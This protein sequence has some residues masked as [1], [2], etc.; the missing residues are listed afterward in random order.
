MKNTTPTPN[1]SLMTLVI[2]AVL[3]ALF[4]AACGPKEAPITVPAD[5]QAG[6][7]IVEPCT[8]KISTGM[9]KS[10]KYDADC[11]TLVVPENRSDPNSRLIALPVVRVRATGSN[12]VEPIFW[13][14]GGPNSNVTPA[15]D[16]A[17]LNGLIDDR[18][19]V[20]VGYRG[21][22]GSVVLQ[23][24]EVQ[25]ALKASKILFS[26]SALDSVEASLTQCA[27]RF[28]AEGVDLDGY[29]IMEIVDDMEAARVALGY[30]R[31]NLLSQSF[32]SRV[33]MIYAWRYPDSLYR[34]VM[35]AAI[36]PGRFVT[37]P[38]KVDEQLEYYAALCA[39]D[40]KR[41][42]CSTRTDDLA[43]T[44]RNVLHD[45]PKR[46]LFMPI[47]E[48]SVKAA[49]RLLLQQTQASGAMSGPG[50]V[51]VWIA[52][53]KGDASGLAMATLLSKM[54]IPG[55]FTWGAVY[56]H[57]FSVDL[58][59]SRDYRAELNPPGSIIGA[60]VSYLAYGAASGWPVKLI[61]QEYRQVQPSDVEMLLVSGPLDFTAPPGYVTEELMPHLSNGQQVILKDF[62]HTAAFW[63]LQPEARV[64]LLTSFY[65]T[66][67]ADDS[68]YTYQPVD[69]HVGLG[70][71]EM[72]KLLVAIPV[73]IIVIVVAVV[74]FV[75]RRVRRRRASQVPS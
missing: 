23:C 67:V 49:S 37:E 9:F 39:Q 12:P 17:R 4:L 47:D 21:L 75:A 71:P 42:G 8:Y 13:L 60:P 56:S 54:A 32:G 69:F 61:P 7:L 50:I 15:D 25:E 40:R 33:A 35:Y 28:Q 16:T 73:L 10:V 58:D 65:N 27:G 6:D 31:I 55:G 29:N 64:R 30:E 72:A 70:F 44:V 18:D 36:P 45:M 59:P 66:G 41:S 68:L 19:F 43:E 62:G 46:W 26:D 1:R 52:A 20:M 2:I 74:W 51:D 24:P 34:V 11:G 22:D 63:S 14:V 48:D 3:A 57:M 5:A 53:D 38:E